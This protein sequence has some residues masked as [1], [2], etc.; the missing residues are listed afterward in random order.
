MRR[1]K[2]PPPAGEGCGE[3]EHTLVDLVLTFSLGGRGNSD[4]NARELI[5]ILGRHHT[6]LWT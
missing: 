3:E 1:M 4:F 2:S 5:N 6:G